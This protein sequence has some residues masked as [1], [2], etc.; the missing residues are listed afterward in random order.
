DARERADVAAGW[1]FEIDDGYAL[2]EFD[3]EIALLGAR[4]R[5]DDW[6]RVY[7]SWKDA[8]A[9]VCPSVGPARLELVDPCGQPVDMLRVVVDGGLPDPPGRLV[10]RGGQER[11]GL[12]H[13]RPAG[14]RLRPADVPGL[15]AQ[16]LEERGVQRVDVDVMAFV[17]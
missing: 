3:I 5:H 17:G 7:S 16:R 2:F 13:P 14:V 8:A 10:V 12:A 15:V 4:P 1:A 9:A 6:P 11:P